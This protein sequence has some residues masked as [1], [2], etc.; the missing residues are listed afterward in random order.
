MKSCPRSAICSSCLCLPLSFIRHRRDS[1]ASTL[2]AQ[3]EVEL[4]FSF[5][6]A[7]SFPAAVLL[8]RLP[9]RL[10]G[11]RLFNVFFSSFLVLCTV[12]RIPDAFPFF[13]CI[14]DKHVKYV[15]I[16]RNGVQRPAWIF[17]Y[18]IVA[19]FVVESLGHFWPYLCPKIMGSGRSLN[20]CKSSSSPHMSFGWK[21]LQNCESGEFLSKIQIVVVLHGHCDH[22]RCWGFLTVKM[23]LFFSIK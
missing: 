17:L 16:R 22:R 19:L 8:H 1:Q 6:G 14:L 2:W 4:E 18:P 10:V 9:L 21:F 7:L 5:F 15:I 11:I 3:V 13:S 23:C 20:L 12:W